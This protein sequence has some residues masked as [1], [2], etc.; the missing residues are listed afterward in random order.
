MPLPNARIAYYIILRLKKSGYNPN[1][2]M[3]LI[4]ALI[5]WTYDPVLILTFHLNKP[6]YK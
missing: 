1:L 4:K 5:K 3:E 6:R 2:T